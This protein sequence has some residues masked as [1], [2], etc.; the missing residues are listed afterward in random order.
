MLKSDVA[1]EREKI[2]ALES[3]HKQNYKPHGFVA[4]SWTHFV[5]NHTAV[6]LGIEFP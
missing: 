3:V 5:V 6:Q 4:S 1:T 2:V